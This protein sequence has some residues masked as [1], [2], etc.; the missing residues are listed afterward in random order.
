M[1]Y[2]ITAKYNQLLITVSQ[3][4]LQIGKYVLFKI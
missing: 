2:Q 1:I 3:N 4:E